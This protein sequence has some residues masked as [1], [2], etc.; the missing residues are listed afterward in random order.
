[1]GHAGEVVPARR[2][3][4]ALLNGGPTLQPAPG[5]PRARLSLTGGAAEYLAAPAD[6]SL[7]PDTWTLQRI[8]RDALGALARV[9]CGWPRTVAAAVAI[10]LG[11]G[12]G[13][14]LVL[15][16]DA[17]TMG[18]LAERIIG[19]VLVVAAMAAGGYVLLTGVRLVAAMSAWGRIRPQDRVLTPGA[20][21]TPA[22]AVR[23]VGAVL[24]LAGA[25]VLIVRQ[26]NLD[27]SLPT[28]GA[29]ALIATGLIAGLGVLGSLLAV[30][31]GQRAPAAPVAAATGAGQF[32]PGG[33][34]PAGPPAAADPQQWQPDAGQPAG[35]LGAA[36][37]P[38]ADPWAAQQP[39]PGQADAQP[40]A[41]HAQ[42]GQADA[43][44]WAQHAQ[45]GQAD[46]QP[47]AQHAQPG[48]PEPG[49][50]P[51][52]PA[53]QGMADQQWAQL[54]QP[55]QS[56]QPGQPDAQP[57]AQPPAEPGQPGAAAWAQPTAE[58]GAPPAAWTAQP[59]T[60]GHGPGAPV[61]PPSAAVPPAGPTTD[62]HDPAAPVPPPSVA[63][64]PAGPTT[65]DDDFDDVEHTRLVH[66]HVPAA[67][68]ED[69]TRAVRAAQIQV[70]LSDGRHLPLNA[71]TLLG[72][73]PQSRSGE[74]VE[75][76]L[77][78]DDPA[79][80]KTHLAVRVEGNKVWVTDRAS[81]NG[82]SV[83]GPGGEESDL[84]PWQET[85]VPVGGEVRFG[86]VVLSVLL[87]ETAG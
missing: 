79:V 83:K 75:G 55:G 48:Q 3:R 52:P 57:W 50:W 22:F 31:L 24:A 70:L 26:A 39:Q 64:P 54:P 71:T 14:L 29:V 1:M 18:G 23:V 58:A 46:A 84:E 80:S 51:A 73:A 21:F 19:F 63:V 49:A 86:H 78:V 34:A 62:R 17:I 81:T 44:P 41:Q 56:P 72:R 67:V 33:Y 12:G 85:L 82:T 7:W 4:A 36:A 47:W 59:A 61:P 30:L 9:Y 25:I 37:A 11:A 5:N 45:P 6:R 77:E 13:F 66:R 20:L 68:R 38:G 28:V 16:H 87:D 2:T 65:E 74:E 27:T 69:A 43:Q 8:R 15:G 42:P 53:Q 60:D 40:W 10:L 35:Q 76:L 32:A